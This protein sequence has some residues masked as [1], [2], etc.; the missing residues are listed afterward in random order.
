MLKPAPPP[1]MKEILFTFIENLPVLIEFE[2]AKA[3]LLREKFTALTRAGFTE[4]QALK[5]VI[6][7]N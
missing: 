6:E 2:K 5:I 7:G 4:D 1:S 3:T